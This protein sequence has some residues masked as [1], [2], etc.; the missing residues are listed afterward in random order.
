MDLGSGGEKTSLHPTHLVLLCHSKRPQADA[1]GTWR[2]WVWASRACLPGPVPLLLSFHLL[3][4]LAH[5]QLK[6]GKLSLYLSS[7]SSTLS[8]T[9]TISETHTFPLLSHA[10]SV[11]LLPYHELVLL[12]FASALSSVPKMA[13]LLVHWYPIIIQSNNSSFCPTH[14]CFCHDPIET[15]LGIKR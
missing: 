4:L 11:F 6:L 2:V 5:V 3:P 10:Q 15:V 9:Q 14:L 1:K 7:S 12:G 13:S 8:L